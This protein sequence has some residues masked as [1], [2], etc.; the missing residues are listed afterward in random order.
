LIIVDTNVVSEPFKPQPS[1]AVIGWL[2]RQ[3]SQEL[4][5]TTVSLAELYR[6][7]AIMPDGRRKH[8]MKEDTDNFRDSYFGD[9]VLAFDTKA[10]FAYADMSAKTRAR[11]YSM[12]FAD[13]QIAAI[14]LSY[15]FAVATRDV[16]PFEAA[17]VR[18]I[19]P[20]TAG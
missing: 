17:G 18:V 6:G 1:E 7:I 14:A 16:E 5:L 19:N 13:A 20:W 9:R 15:G 4:F 3:L 10:A 11:G 12:S 8:G 2:D